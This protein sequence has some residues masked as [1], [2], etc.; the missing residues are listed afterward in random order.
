MWEPLIYS[1]RCREQ[2]GILN[3]NLQSVAG[4]SEA[5]GTEGSLAELN[6]QLWGLRLSLGRKCQRADFF[7]TL[8]V[9]ENCLLVCGE[10]P[11]LELVRGPNLMGNCDT[12]Y[13]EMLQSYANMAATSHT[14]LLAA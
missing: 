2:T 3:W 11:T 4:W 10:R 5:Q 14:G 13:D 12:S 9:S 1:Q 7:N 8:L 6:H